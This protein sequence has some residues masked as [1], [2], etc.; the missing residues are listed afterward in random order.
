MNSINWLK[1]IFTEKLNPKQFSAENPG[2]PR[3]L[4]LKS[5]L[6]RFGLSTPASA[7][8]PKL[9]LGWLLGK[10]WGNH[11]KSWKIHCWINKIMIHYIKSAGK[12]YFSMFFSSLRCHTISFSLEPS[13]QKLLVNGVS[14]QYLVNLWGRLATAPLSGW[15]VPYDGPVDPGF[16]IAVDRTATCDGFKGRW[17]RLGPNIF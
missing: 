4:G 7:S 3:G 5:A 6:S 16:H 15:K 8:F 2:H 10:L 1:P 17:G 9:H 13:Q 11:E 12:P 14:G